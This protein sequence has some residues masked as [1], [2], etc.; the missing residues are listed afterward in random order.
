MIITAVMI[1]R[2]R[3][4]NRKRP[5]TR[6]GDETLWRGVSA[7]VLD[8]GG[9]LAPRLRREREGCARAIFGVADLD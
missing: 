9:E 1:M 6:S 4:G 3:A 5:V 8:L 7:C 2:M